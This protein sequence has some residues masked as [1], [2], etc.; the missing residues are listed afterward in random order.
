MI[1]YV[2]FV[3]G[4]LILLYNIHLFEGIFI[5]KYLI[6]FLLI[7]DMSSIWRYKVYGFVILHNVIMILID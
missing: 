3:L 2:S 5:G 7:P 4:F 1:T 6:W